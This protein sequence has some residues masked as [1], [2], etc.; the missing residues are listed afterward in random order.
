MNYFAKVCRKEKITKPEISKKR[1]VN[2]VDEEPHP[3]DSVNFLRTNNLYES[4]YNSE[5]D[6]TVALIENDIAK[7]GP[8]NMPIEIGNIPNTPLVDSGS[9]CS[10]LNRSLAMQVVKSGLHAVWIH[11]EVSPQLRTFSNELIHSEGKIQ[12]PIAESDGHRFRQFSPS[13]RTV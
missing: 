5:E 11:E 1:T 2:T 12:T 7:I 6:N 10:T 9:A 8:L 3:E 4:D 13:L